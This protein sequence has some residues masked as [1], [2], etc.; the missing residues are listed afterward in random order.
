MVNLVPVY[1]EI[2]RCFKR[3]PTLDFIREVA[4]ENGTLMARIRNS[5][6]SR[7][8]LECEDCPGKI[9]VAEAYVA[10]WIEN[11][12]RR[13]GLNPILGAR[14]LECYSERR[15]KDR[16]PHPAAEARPKKGILSLS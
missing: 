14:C 7:E 15:D 16:E 2:P 3:T 9:T 8:F 4:E 5:S 11:Y 6:L 13:L 1:G 12:F 10:R